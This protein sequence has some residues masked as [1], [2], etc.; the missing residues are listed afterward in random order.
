MHSGHGTALMSRPSRSTFRNRVSSSAFIEGS[1]RSFGHCRDLADDR[2]SSYRR[3]ESSANGGNEASAYEAAQHR[4][5]AG[6][7]EYLLVHDLG[8]DDESDASERPS[9]R[10]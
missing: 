6:R 2:F 7:R 8:Q 9:S 5:P 1:T 3:G 4:S 10:A